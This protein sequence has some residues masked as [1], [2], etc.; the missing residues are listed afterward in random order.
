M[1]KKLVLLIFV[2]ISTLSAYSQNSV[3]DYKYVIVPSKFDFLDEADE[4]RLNS[5]S[6]FLFNKYGF[7]AIKEYEEFPEELINNPCL[8]LK[9]N[10]IHDSGT[11][12]TKLKISLKN[13]KNKEVFVSQAGES[14]EKKYA[15]AYNNALRDAFL[16]V[17]ALNYTYK[18]NENILAYGTL[19]NKA[20]RQEIDLLKKELD[21]LKEDKESLTT[22]SVVAP[23]ESV[24]GKADNV[25][26]IHESYLL[27]QK[28]SSGYQL[29][30]TSSKVVMVLLNTR[31]SGVFMVQDKNAVVFKEDELWILSENNGNTVTNTKLNINL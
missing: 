29:I 31:K 23:I 28:T 7:I 5:I 1:F 14:F 19:P 2:F 10:L 8:G 12:K 9:S 24:K 13:C 16:Y 25:S 20:A 6:H 11:F 18:P 30:D 3:N 4:F 22:Q 21:K 15:A 17:K 26:E 27:A